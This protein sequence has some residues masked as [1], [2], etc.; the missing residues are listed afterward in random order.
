MFGVTVEPRLFGLIGDE[1]SLDQKINKK[2][3]L[4]E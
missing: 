2:S 4:A 3:K 1:G